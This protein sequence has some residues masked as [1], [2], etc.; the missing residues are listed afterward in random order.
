MKL[1][2]SSAGNA[3]LYIIDKN[4]ILVD[5]GIPFR[6]LQDMLMEHGY[7]AERLT[8]IFIS[9]EHM[10]H[11][12]EAT[13]KQ[14]AKVNK[15]VRIFAPKSVWNKSEV[16]ITNISENSHIALKSGLKV[17]LFPLVH[18]VE[19]F[20]F[21][22]NDEILHITD[23]GD[24]NHVINYVLRNN[25]KLKYACVECN[26]VEDVIN[27]N[28][29][30]S[31]DNGEMHRLIRVKTTHLSSAKYNQFVKLCNPEFY[32]KAHMSSTNYEEE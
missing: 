22:F 12:N 19:G 21:I 32:E 16:F 1:K 30:N 31:K 5:C 10:D 20:G 23:T 2:S 7:S 6:T 15:N 26:F 25:I 27:R 18:D 24:V 11:F 28:I 17:K 14:I 3:Y 29:S 8:H 9:H 4:V 13:L